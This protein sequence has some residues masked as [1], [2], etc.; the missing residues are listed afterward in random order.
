MKPKNYIE[1]SIISYLTS[2]PSRDVIVI[3]N[4]QITDEW[5]R[6]RRGDF[7]LFI[8]ELVQLEAEGGDPEAAK[9]RMAAIQGIPVLTLSAETM[10]FSESLLKSASLPQKASADALHIASAAINGLD[11][12]LT[13]NFKYIANAA[14]RV[15]VEKN[16]GNKDMSP[17][18]SAHLRS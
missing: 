7:E 10:E 8:S 16:V 1:T 5:W 12:L 14:I 4:Q 3:A 15:K 13:W 2:R 17:R 6:F 18:L 9:K 11:Y